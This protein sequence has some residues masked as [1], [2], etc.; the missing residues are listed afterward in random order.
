MDEIVRTW[1]NIY[2]LVEELTYSDTD[3]HSDVR[4]VSTFI[5][6]NPAFSEIW[7]FRFFD[8]DGKELRFPIK[9]VSNTEVNRPDMVDN[10]Q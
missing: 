10:D 7:H 8:V 1:T 9:L 2:E 3:I 6:S 4:K 5:K